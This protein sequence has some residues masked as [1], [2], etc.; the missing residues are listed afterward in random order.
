MS[1]ICVST[2]SPDAPA[3]AAR[4]TTRM[5]RYGQTRTVLPLGSGTA[6]GRS[7]H[8]RLESERAPVRGPDGVT[9]LVDGEIFDAHGP[10]SDPAAAIAALYRGGRMNE[11]AYLNGSFAAIVVD[12]P[13]STV[14]LATDRLASRS[15][16]VWRDGARLSVA[17]RLEA[18]LEDA[19]VPRRLSAQGLMELLSY[20]RT[21][22]DH[23]QYAGVRSLPA[24]RVLSFCGGQVREAQ[25][26]RLAWR[27]PECSHRETA[28]RLE[29][30]IRNAVARRTSDRVRHGLL[31]SGGIDARVMLGAARSAGRTLS[32]ATAGTWDNLEVQIARATARM[33]SAPFRFLENPPANIAASF[34][35]ATDVSDGLFPAPTNLFALMPGL[36]RDHDVLLSGHGLDYTLR[37]YY[38]PCVMLRVAG[39]VSRLPRLRAIPDGAPAT[40]E[41]NMRV[42]IGLAGLERALAP[43]VRAELR[44]RRVRAM[45]A[46]LR[47]VDVLSPYDSWDAF[48]LHNLGRHYAY[49][50]FTAM[51]AVVAHRAPA[52]DDEI[53]DLYL[54]M[55]PKWRA[56]G[57][58]VHRAMN[59]IAPDLMGLPDANTDISARLAFPVQ[60]ALVFAR[61]CLRRLGLFRLP[62]PP[63]PAMSHGSW[64]RYGEV[65]RRDPALRGRL[66][67]LMRSDAL[68][69]TGVFDR[70]GLCGV[71]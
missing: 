66:E 62:P 25:T 45:E 23:T 61:A 68:L 20:Q 11:A 6:A 14:T 56:S 32:C 50:D 57:A 38:M 12:E 26:R 5:A 19:A 4:M 70:S 54:S 3:I 48:I 10:I 43:R 7:F 2:G 22:A 44:E 41:R 55:P 9:V 47:E 60:L 49:S 42:G 52:F 15:L 29:S 18:L 16:F 46:A 13:R 39:S 53:F 69:D 1:G 27:R 34:D 21:L 30:A 35:D 17:S 64:A 67:G 8:G 40:V 63:D 36:A 24:A 65:F 31:L 28:V 58:A 37:G 51:E 33:A 71:I 59:R